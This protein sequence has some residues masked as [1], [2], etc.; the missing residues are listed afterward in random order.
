MHVSG[1]AGLR[2]G[3]VR[4]GD[5]PVHARSPLRMRLWLTLIGIANAVA[6]VILF[7]FLDSPPFLIAFAVLGV[8]ALIN[9]AVVLRH[10]R[11]GPHYQPGPAI[12]P[13]RPVEDT[14]PARAERTLTP[15][16]VRRNRYLIMMGTCVLLIALAWG[17]IRLYSVTAAVA[18]SV[19]ASLIPPLASIIANVDSP[20]NQP[21]VRRAA[22]DE[23]AEDEW[24]G[25]ER[26]DGEPRGRDDEAR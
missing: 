2:T 5:E 13:Y 19:V 10:L 7:W 1:N 3:H 16:R 24:A 20:I 23:R 26:A 21:G 22:E 6:G 11:Q 8:V 15:E 4:S 18:M 14:R 25:D 12:P 17:W 9:L